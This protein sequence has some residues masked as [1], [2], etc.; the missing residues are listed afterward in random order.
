MIIKKI[1]TF[2]L[3][4][5]VLNIVYPLVWLFTYDLLTGNDTLNAVLVHN[6]TIFSPEVIFGFYTQYLISVLYNSSKFFGMAM[7]IIYFVLVFN[8]FKE[9]KNYTE[10]A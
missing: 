5:W 6:P 7:G 1:I 3:G 10:E 8:L 9:I 2:F 4:F